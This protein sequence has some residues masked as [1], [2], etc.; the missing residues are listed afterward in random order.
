MMLNCW[1]KD[2]VK[3]SSHSGD[4]LFQIPINLI[5]QGNFGSTLNR[6]RMLNYL[7]CMSKFIRCLLISKNKTISIAS[8]FNLDIIQI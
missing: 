7:K 2:E 8:R 6:T 4:I 5:G 3:R 1:I